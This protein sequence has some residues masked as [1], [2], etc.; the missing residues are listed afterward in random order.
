MDSPQRDPDCIFCK[1]VAG[2][3]PATKVLEDDQVLAFMDIGP[4]AQ[5][6]VL[7]IPKHHYERIDEMP[8]A[9]AGAVLSQ[10]PAIVAAAGLATGAAGVNVLQNN[11]RIAGQLVPHVH[12]HIIPRLP[13]GAFRFNWPAGEYPEGRMDELAGLIRQNIEKEAETK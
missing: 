10:L 2:E 11:G 12:F 5:G 3:I 8:P 13:G 1:I 6:H 9:R 7:L 4:V